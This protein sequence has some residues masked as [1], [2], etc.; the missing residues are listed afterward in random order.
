MDREQDDET[1]L[2]QH[3][4]YYSE[5][6]YPDIEL[7]STAAY[8]MA[9]FQP[10]YMVV[11]PMGLDY[12]GELHGAHSAEYERQLILQ[13]QI[14]A[15][16]L[17]LA[18]GAGYSVLITGDHGIDDNGCHNGTSPDVRRV[19]LYLLNANF[20]HGDSDRIVSQLQIAP[21]ICELLGI[22]AAPTMKAHSLLSTHNTT[23]IVS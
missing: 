17:P 8:L 22:P 19:P 15:N 5:D 18:L 13:D 2:I 23:T 16:I 10:D 21:T 3:G 20:A 9:R 14:M 7:F 11:H 6:S 4:R 12:I 1:Q